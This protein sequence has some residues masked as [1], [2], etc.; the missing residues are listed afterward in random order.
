MLLFSRS[1]V[2]NYLQPMDCGMSGFPVLH[3]LLELAQTHFHWVS[4]VIQLS[5]SLSS[6]S[7]P[8]SFQASGSFLKS[9]LCIRWPKY[10]RFSFSINLSNEYSGLFSFKID[11]F[12]LL[13]V[14]G[15]PKSLLQ[16][17]SLKASIL[18]CSA[19]FKVQFSHPYM[20]T[21]K[22]VALTRQTLLAF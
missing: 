5:H 14:Q 3:H 16:H 21:G 22:T 1:V 6:S 8:A 9:W 10:W 19:F 11:W 13:V 20:T 12:D 4:D 15:T 2:S 7:P 18:W 17:Q